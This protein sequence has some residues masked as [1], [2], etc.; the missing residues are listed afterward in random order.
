[1]T[2]R[3]NGVIISIHTTENYHPSSDGVSL[4]KPRSVYTKVSSVW[5]WQ[6]DG[7]AIQTRMV[8]ALFVN[9]SLSVANC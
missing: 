7:M 5:A 4:K 2:F 8:W 1:M 9:H 6:A 3:T